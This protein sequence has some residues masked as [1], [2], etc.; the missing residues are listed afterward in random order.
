MVEA[1]SVKVTE[2]L[3][4]NKRR[5]EA[6]KKMWRKKRKDYIKKER[7][8]NGLLFVTWHHLSPVN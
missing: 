4:K 6:E 1:Q 8:Y 5:K 2:K 3:C 7:D